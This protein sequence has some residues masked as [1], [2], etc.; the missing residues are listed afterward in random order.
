[1]SSKAKMILLMVILLWASA[2][3]GIRAGLQDYS[4]EGL[5]LLRFLVAS[6]CISVV[7]FRLPQRNRMHWRDACSLLGI[8]ILG[9][10]I[11]NITLNYGE[12]VVSSGMASFII[13][14]SPIITAILAIT[15]LG[16]RLSFLRVLGFLISVAGIALIAFGEKGGLEWDRNIGYILI[17]TCVSSLFNLLQK[18]YLKKYHAIEVA[19]YIVWGGTLFLAFYFPRLQADLSHASLNTT[20]TVIYL[21]IFPAAIGYLGWSYVLS[22]I[23][24]SRATLFLYFMPVIAMGL[25]WL[26]L[27]EIPVWLSLLGGA[28][29]MVG[30]W[31]VNY[32]YRLHAAK[33]S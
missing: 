27:D 13:S 32:S 21:G 23:P 4:P 2:F 14:Q 25:G 28:L 11:Y 19:T 18:P 7:Y 12:I 9:I 26:F 17:A 31:L 5:A 30:V 33:A 16:E 22:E 1:M 8:G 29:A 3:V 20:L 6:L 15:F 10:G 24:A